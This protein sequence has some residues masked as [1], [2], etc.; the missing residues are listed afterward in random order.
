MVVFCYLYAYK[1]VNFHIS[2]LS[3]GKTK[4]ESVMKFLIP[5][6]NEMVTKKITTPVVYFEQKE[7]ERGSFL[8]R[9]L[10][11]NPRKTVSFNG[12][13]PIPSL[14]PSGSWIHE[15]DFGTRVISRPSKALNTDVAIVILDGGVI[16]NLLALYSRKKAKWIY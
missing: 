5:T 15:D 13:E 9:K 7:N 8:Y 2:L 1:I 14:K 12:G 4:K 11:S 16:D 6:F 3:V 10:I